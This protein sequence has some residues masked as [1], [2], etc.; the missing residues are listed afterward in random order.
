MIS[1]NHS[2]LNN[3]HTPIDN[4][5]GA[6]MGSDWLCASDFADR[7]SDFFRSLFILSLD[8]VSCSFMT[9]HLF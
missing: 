7:P 3:V 1:V 6:A 2:R 4:Q 9:L 8:N 5:S